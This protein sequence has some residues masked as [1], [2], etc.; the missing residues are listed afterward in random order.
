[1]EQDF[2]NRI[3]ADTDDDNRSERLQRDR[4]CDERGAASLDQL[5]MKPDKFLV[6]SN[7]YLQPQQDQN[8]LTISVKERPDCLS[9]FVD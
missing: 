7:H 9:H 2:A 8:R 6:K 5:L 1:M 3:A 4:E